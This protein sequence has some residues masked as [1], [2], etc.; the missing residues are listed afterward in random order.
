LCC[1]NR[2]HRQICSW[3]CGLGRGRP[4]GPPSWG[5]CRSCLQVRCICHVCT[6]PVQHATHNY[7]SKFIHS[8]VHETP[9]SLPGASVNAVSAQ[10]CRQGQSYICHD[11][12]MHALFR[13]SFVACRYLDSRQTCHLYNH[14]PRVDCLSLK[15]ASNGRQLCNE[16]YMQGLHQHD[17]AVHASHSTMEQSMYHTACAELF[18]LA[19]MA[20]ANHMFTNR[21]DVSMSTSLQDQRAKATSTTLAS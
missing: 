11:S 2:T 13:Q 7:H 16:A 5:P 15:H 4:C 8:F 3:W 20:A 9:W 21:A 14:L 18:C 12:H 19:N 6:Y 10:G 1:R 17:E